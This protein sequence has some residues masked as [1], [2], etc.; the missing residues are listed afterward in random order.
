[1][2]FT[3]TPDYISFWT[4]YPEQYK[5]YSVHF[6]L[7]LDV[8]HT[9][10]TTYDLLDMISDIG[11]VIEFCYIVFNLFA[12]QFSKVRLKALLTSRLFQLTRGLKV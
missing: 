11:G 10:R 5:F 9:E 2:G 4:N 1:M 3:L 12:V 6:E 8:K 7:N